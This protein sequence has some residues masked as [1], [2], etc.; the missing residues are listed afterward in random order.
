MVLEEKK[1][2]HISPDEIQPNPENP[3]VIFRQ[4]ELESLMTSIAKIGIQVPITVYQDNGKYYLLDGERRWRCAKKLNLN[5][6]PALIQEKPTELEN[7]LLMYNIHALRE[8]W[9]YYTIASKL[10]RIIDLFTKEKHY[11]PNE[12]ELSEATGLTRGQIRRCQLLLNMPPHY[13]DLLLEEL[14]L[15]KSKQKLSEDFFIEMERS[16]KT[17]T[18]RFPEFKPKLDDIRVTLIDKFR[19]GTIGAVTDFRQLAKMATSVQTLGIAQ[20]TVISALQEVFATDNMTNIKDTFKK[21]V[22]FEYDEHKAYKQLTFLTDYVEEVIQDNQIDQLDNDFI[23]ELKE[24]YAQL[25][26]IFE[27]QS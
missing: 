17:V 8:Q 22:E 25:K 24:L 11:N 16:L 12:I 4:E 1:L 19:E 15:P 7:L 10:Q 21:T 2:K 20:E 14:K 13:H 26:Q 6:I 23:N 3:R 9:D 27:G 5:K 18:N